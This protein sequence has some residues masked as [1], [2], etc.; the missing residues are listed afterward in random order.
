MVNN[1]VKLVA[2]NLLR[3]NIAVNGTM[4]DLENFTR[5]AILLKPDSGH[6]ITLKRVIR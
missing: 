6:R 4:Y 2:Q 3:G 5:D 1:T